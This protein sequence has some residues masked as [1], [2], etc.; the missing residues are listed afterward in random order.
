ME[1][2]Q[3][4]VRLEHVSKAFGNRTVLNDVTLQI[5]VGEA[6]CL[7]GRSG[8]GQSVTLKLMIGLIKPDQGNISIQG[9]EI[10][11]LDPAKLSAV[12]KKVG[13]LFQ[14]A[15]LFDSISVGENVAF[16]LRGYAQTRWSR[17]RLSSRSGH[18]AG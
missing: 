3:P 18:P 11:S 9:E 16:P 12:R 7:L 15:A 1:N 2:D 10:Q 6:F 4:A 8:V 13:S 17:S 5:R 14:S